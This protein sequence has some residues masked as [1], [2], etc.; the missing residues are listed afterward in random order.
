MLMTTDGPKKTRQSNKVQHGNKEAFKKTCSTVQTNFSVTFTATHKH[1]SNKTAHISK[2]NSV[3]RS[4][5]Y[6]V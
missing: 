2:I 3:A 5:H 4:F 6:K 1:Q